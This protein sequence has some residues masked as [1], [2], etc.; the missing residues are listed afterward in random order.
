MHYESDWCVQPTCDRMRQSVLINPYLNL[1]PS[2][3]AAFNCITA[4]GIRTLNVLSEAR[5]S[6]SSALGFASTFL[7]EFL[8][9]LLKIVSIQNIWQLIDCF[10]KVLLCNCHHSSGTPWPHY[11]RLLGHPLHGYD[12]CQ[13]SII[14][15][16]ATWCAIK[17]H[18]SAGVPS[19]RR[20]RLSHPALCRWYELHLH[21]PQSMGRRAQHFPCVYLLLS[22][23]WN[24]CVVL[25]AHDKDDMRKFGSC[26]HQFI[27]PAIQWLV[28][29]Y[30]CVLLAHLVSD[31]HKAIDHCCKCIVVICWCLENWKHPCWCYKRINGTCGFV[32]CAPRRNWPIISV[33]VYPWHHPSHKF[34]PC[35]LPFLIA[36]W[37]EPLDLDRVVVTE[38]RRRSL[39][40]WQMDVINSLELL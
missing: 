11:E 22:G 9:E 37:T 33:I 19:R 25:R 10:A 32:E 26:T 3:V 6:N 39:S 18:M 35:S 40:R 29:C 16:L 7:P 36:A 27:T 24:I 28:S 14:Q 38:W 15:T 20:S 17:L 4:A 1:L 2:W 34:G 12:H 23:S 21:L 8:H 31:I 5:A 30:D 13:P